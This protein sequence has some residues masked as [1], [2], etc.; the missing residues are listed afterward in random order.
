MFSF[1]K[2]VFGLHIG[3]VGRDIP[4]EC[5]QRLEDLF[6]QK[7]VF[8]KIVVYLTP[9]FQNNSILYVTVILKL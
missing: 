1:L 4:A 8:M 9:N 7:K 2:K 3:I 6:G 5:K